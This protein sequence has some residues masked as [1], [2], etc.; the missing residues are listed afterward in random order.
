MRDPLA[1]RVRPGAAG[2]LEGILAIYNPYVTG[3]AA[4]FETDPLRPSDRA[5]WLAAHLAGGR[6]RLFVAETADAQMVG[7]ATTSPFRPRAGYGTTVES[8]VYCRAGSEG[9]GIGTRLYAALFRAIAAED[10]ERIVAGIA[11]PNPASVALHRRFGFREIGVFTRVG[12]KFG[13]YWDVAWFERPA[14]LDA[15]QAATPAAAYSIE[16]TSAFM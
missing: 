8:S 10:L 16:E 11:L 7:W 15:V 9:R 2:D 1:V 3:S 13:R 14:R 12:R 6:H 4:T 5:E